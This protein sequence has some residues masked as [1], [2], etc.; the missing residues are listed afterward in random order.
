MSETNG[1]GAAGN[2]GGAGA[3]ALSGRQWL[4][5]AVLTLSTFLVLLD[6]S[7]VN[8]ALPQIVGDLDGTLDQ[9][10]WVVAGFILAFAAPLVLFGKLGDVFGRRRL[11]V[12]GVA[13]FALASLGCALA[14]SMNFLIAARVG[15]GVG[16]A[17]L[18]PAT[19]AL[20]KATFPRERLG[21]AFG[22]QGITAGVATAVGPTLGGVLTTSF[23][24]RWI[25]L[26]NIPV[27]LVAIGAILLAVAESRAEGASRRIDVPGF[28][29]SG[30]GVF[31]LVFALVEGQRLGWDSSPI[32]GSLAAATLSFVAFVL[33]ERRV[34]NPLVNLSLFGDRLFAV[35][36]A[37]RGVTLF[38]LLAAV[39][40][41]PLYWQT[42]LGYSALQAGLVLLPLSVVS[43]FLSPIA[44]SLADKVDVRWLV[45]SGFLAVAAS[46]LWL[47]RLTPESGWVFFAAPLAL[48]GAGLAFLFAPTVTATL[49]NVPDEKSGVAS[50]VSFTAGEIGAALGV[51]V[52]A[53]VLQNR[54][55]ANAEE[56][57][58]A[59]SLGL[60]PGARDGILSGLSEG[61]TGA[62]AGL[63]GSAAGVEVLIQG[64]FADA[65][66]SGLFLVA[67]AALF[68]A[69]LAF[70]FFS[71]RPEPDAG[72][73]TP[74]GSGRPD[75]ASDESKTVTAKDAGTT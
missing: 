69:L 49:R 37:L 15:Q 63:G 58:S 30:A 25:F 26:I 32:L 48:F 5:L 75:E 18:E 1:Y 53:A 16:G 41:L 50:G 70:V 57:L 8:V 27:G 34:R 9:A 4:T 68:G 61:A 40:V 64:A 47:S 72:R 56:A 36:N 39:F 44:G 19:L 43:F 14:P 66:G 67:A 10:T 24:W 38:V 52:A 6:A 28:L 13:V 74:A 12:L 23:S 71:A 45:G 60:P 22:V 17:M 62:P 59:A 55:L 29:L 21:L 54:L 42:Q 2:S 11:F 73:E 3:G 35:G 31:F 65:V 20:I 46:A 7:V 33:V 51:A